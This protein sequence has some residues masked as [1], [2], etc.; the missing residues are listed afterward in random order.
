VRPSQIGRNLAVT[1]I[2]YTGANPGDFLTS[3]D[4]CTGTG[5]T[6]MKSCTISVKFSPTAIGPRSANLTITDNVNGV[7]GSQQTVPLT[8]NGT[9]APPTV[10][11]TTPANGAS[12]LPGQVVNATYSC[13]DGQG[14]PGIQAC[15]GTVPNGSPIDT[16]TPGSHSFT[17]T[18]KSKD[19]QSATTSVA[20][21]VGYKISGGGF[22][23]PVGNAPSVNTG[24]AGQTIPL[25]WQLT[26]ANGGFI[27]ALSAVTSITYKPTTC[28]SFSN[29]PTGSV[30]T[31][32]TGGSTLRYDST[33]NQF[34]Y[35]WATPSTP[36]CYT[37]FLT[38]DRSTCPDR[39]TT[40]EGRLDDRVRPPQM[41]PFARL[42]CA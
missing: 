28:G 7:P 14:G 13:T 11:V 5:V 26:N 9:A 22:L 10:S 25:K 4:S 33:A 1:G 39:I 23:A 24:N 29:D 17:V 12:F 40:A 41:V 27:S 21:T 32:P 6:P 38:L 37:L 30:P 42:V 36:G 3:A 20:Y 34:I 35:N 31:T 2:T 19:G 8:G 18:A 15:T 16:S